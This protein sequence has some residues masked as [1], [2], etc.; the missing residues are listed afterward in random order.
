MKSGGVSVGKHMNRLS[1]ELQMAIYVFVYVI[2]F[3]KHRNI[4]VFL[5]FLD[6]KMSQEVN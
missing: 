4:F 1:S 5:S 2:F 6:T 3:R